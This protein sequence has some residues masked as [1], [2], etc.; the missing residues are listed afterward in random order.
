MKKILF[1][2]MHEARHGQSPSVVDSWYQASGGDFAEPGMLEGDVNCDVVII[3]GGYTGLSAALELARKG[4]DTVVL[5]AHSIG[6]GASGRNG[7]QIIGG[8]ARDYDVITRLMGETHALALRGIADDAMALLRQRIDTYHIDC[9]LKWGYIFAA[10]KNRQLIECHALAKDHP[11]GHFMDQAMITAHLGTDYYRGGFF[12]PQSGHLHPLKYVRGLAR[13]AIQEG[14]RLFTRTRVIHWQQEAAGIRIITPEG[15][16]RA[17]HLIMAG[18]AYLG[19]VE[20]RIR[21]F[22]MPV[23]THIIATAP[24]PPTLAQT[25]LPSQPAVCDMNFVLNY[26]RKTPDHRLLFG[27]RVS[28]SGFELPQVTELIRRKMVD[29]Y[30]Q[31]ATISVDY[32]WGGLIGITMN[33]LPHLGRISH[34]AWYA[35]GFS[36]H[37]VVLTGM[38]GAILADAIDG[39]LGRFDIM[40]RI[41][42]RPFP[43]GSVLR[44]PSLVMAMMWYRLRDLL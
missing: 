8:Y 10:E 32:S 40:A 25:I 24:M 4:Y 14:V 1:S 43:G 35:Q 21:P 37:G 33:R 29:I 39:Q 31:L 27:G 12:D 34:N 28:Y 5:E 42:H 44:K 17:R 9:D 11:A 19:R 16:V 30:P 13:A 18:N 38:A 6:W 15:V 20:R 36:G 3:G 7:G 26:F 22:I 23:G 2:Y 41:Q